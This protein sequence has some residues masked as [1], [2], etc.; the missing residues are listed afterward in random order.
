[1]CDRSRS[2]GCAPLWPPAAGS[3][4]GGGRRGELPTEARP[5]LKTGPEWTQGWVTEDQGDHVVGADLLVEDPRPG[6]GGQGG[7]WSAPSQASPPRQGTQ[8]STWS[9]VGTGGAKCATVT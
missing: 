4:R 8:A 7:V 9:I 3:T 5:D 1:M 2:R 6:N